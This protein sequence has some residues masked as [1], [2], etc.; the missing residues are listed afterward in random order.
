MTEAVRIPEAPL[1]WR[2]S[3]SRSTVPSEVTKRLL[4][5]D[6]EEGIRTVL[7]RFFRGRGYDVHTA[8]AALPAIELLEQHRFGLPICDV[9]MPGMTGVD[10]VPRA[11]EMDPELAIVMLT[12][13]NDAPTATDVLTHGALDYLMKPIELA[14]LETAV[15]RALHKRDLI[16][17]QRAVERMVR[18]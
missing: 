9:R 5:V 2:P 1:A 13:V 3:T 14:D 7:G 17:Q 16:V 15:Q 10:L 11:H 18:E 12:A 6:D 8:D 4:V